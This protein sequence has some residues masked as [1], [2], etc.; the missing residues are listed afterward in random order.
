MLKRL[1]SLC[2]LSLLFACAEHKP[3]PLQMA[4][5]AEASG[6]FADAS[7]C[8]DSTMH[9][10][11]IKLNVGGNNVLSSPSAVTPITIDLPSTYDADAFQACIKDLGYVLPKVDAQAFLMET[12]RCLDESSG[13]PTP[14]NAYAECIRQGHIEVELIGDKKK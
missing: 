1:V 5:D 3:S 6:Y 7:H 8:F 4:G 10:E 14:Q 9:K 12:K 13:S 11:Q 2:C